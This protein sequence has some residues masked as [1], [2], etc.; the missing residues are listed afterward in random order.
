M[1]A[2]D[3]ATLYRSACHNGENVV[4]SINVS[5]EAV[6]T[7]A[8]SVRINRPQTA[9]LHRSAKAVRQSLPVTGAGLR[10]EDQRN[11]SI[12]NQIVIFVLIQSNGKY[13]KKRFHRREFSSGI[14]YSFMFSL[15]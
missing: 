13:V 12:D 5:V 7:D 8:D 6:P 11:S 10:K 14:F 2:T 1:S 4:L 3:C 9:P 15:G